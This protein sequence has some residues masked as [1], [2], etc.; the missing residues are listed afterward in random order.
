[1]TRVRAALRSEQGYSLI[2]MLV[3]MAIMG[4]IMAGLTTIFVQGSNAELDMNRRFQAQANARIGLDRLKKEIHCASNVSPTATQTG[5]I[6]LTLPSQCPTLGGATTVKWCMLQ[7]SGTRY[8]LYRDTSGGC[9]TGTGKIWVDYM[10]TSSGVGSTPFLYT[11]Q[12]TSSLAKLHV[13]LVVNIKPS[14]TRENFTLSD[15]IVL[16]NSSRT[17]TTGSP[18]P[19]C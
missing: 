17:C 11:Q 5:T 2:E 16:R 7:V 19:P 12:S 6:T 8:G 1:V 15:D 13:D 10:T 9:A 3:V 14:L 18:S 4:V